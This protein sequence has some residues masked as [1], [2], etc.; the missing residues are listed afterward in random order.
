MNP[1]SDSLA[2]GLH[3]RRLGARVAR[4]AAWLFIGRLG[5]QV[6]LV[7]FTLILARRLGEVG[8]GEYFFI[9]SVVFLGNLTSTFGTDM[10]IMRELA[11]KHEATLLPASVVIQV[12]ISIAFILAVFLLAPVL[13]NQST[14]AV[15]ALRIYTLSLIPLAFYTV[16]SSV[17]RGM[18]RMDSFTALNLANGALLV[19]LALLFI[20]PASSLLGL[21][22]WLLIV[23]VVMAILALAVCFVQF[24]ELMR[25]W[26]VSKIKIVANLRLSAPIAVLGFMGAFYQR[27]GVYLLATFL[28]AAATGWF[29]AALRPVEATKIVHFAIMGALFPAMSQ[30]HLG[31]SVEKDAS[32]AKVSTA[33]LKVLLAISVSV[34][35]V[36]S[37]AADPLIPILFGPDFAPA[38]AL[39]RVLAWMLIPL[40]LTHFLS[41]MLLSVRRERPII[42][43]LGASLLVVIVFSILLI[44][45]MG[46]VGVGWAML[47]GET[48]Q[49]AILIYYWRKHT[50]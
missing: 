1:A 16:C 35:L 37:L 19:T 11:A 8:F 46:I 28:G 15:A 38:I 17:L 45:T 9:T 50:A 14:Q 48:M 34:A 18:E 13:P 23:Q 40:T 43:A 29:A 5:S 25:A 3:A 41:L 12:G 24:P 26:N 47:L 44:P 27:A 2:D 10:L 4:N 33:S 20:Q 42:A 6:L 36:F 22:T 49:A 32:F 30:A 39:L 31:S 7:I 21:F